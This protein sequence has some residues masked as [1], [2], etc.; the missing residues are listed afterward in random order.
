MTCGVYGAHTKDDVVFGYG[1]ADG[2]CVSGGDEVGPVGLVGVAVDDLEGS[3]GGHTG[4]LLPAKDG[5]RIVGGIEDSDLLRQAGRGGKG[6]KSGGVQASDIGDVVEVVVLDQVA[7]LD[8]VFSA[9]VLVLMVEVLQPLGE[10][11]SGKTLRTEAGMVAPTAETVTAEDH[12]RTKGWSGH[13][14]I[15][16]GFTGRSA[17]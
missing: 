17:S 2:G 3:V 5:V 4:G 11:D 8:A 13:D 7:V 15:A 10:A 1:Q 6:G 16:M 12:D 9:D 14:E